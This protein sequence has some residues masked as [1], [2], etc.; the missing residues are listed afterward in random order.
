MDKGAWWATVPVS[1]RVGQ[2]RVTNYSTIFSSRVSMFPFLE[3][4]SWWQLM[5]GHRVVTF[6]HLGGVSVSAKE[7]TG[8]DSS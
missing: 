6:S 5:S 2:D 7:L 8:Y 1:Q 3:A 4:S